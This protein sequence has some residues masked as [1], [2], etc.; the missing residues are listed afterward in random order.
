MKKYKIFKNKRTKYHPSVEISVLDDG[1]WENLEITDSP[2][3]NGNYVKFDVNPNP[4]SSKDSFL[5]N[6]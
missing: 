5:E 6:I 1:T 3:S 4:N 2:T